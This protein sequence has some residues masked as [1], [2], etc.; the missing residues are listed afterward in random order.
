MS[1]QKLF[2]VLLA[3][4]FA[5]AMMFT[6]LMAQADTKYWYGGSGRWDDSSHWSKRAGGDV[7][8]VGQPVAGDDVYLNSSDSTN[9]TVTYYN[10][11]YPDAMLGRLEIDAT[12]T[13]TM[14]LQLGDLSDYQ[15]LI[16][17]RE[18]IG[19]S[20]TGTL[21]QAGGSNTNNSLT[22]GTLT[23][24]SGTYNLSGGSLSFTNNEIIGSSGTGVFNQT[25]GTNTTVLG[26]LHVGTSSGG[27]GTYNLSGGSLS[28][29]WEYIGTYGTGIFNQTGGTHTVGAYLY[30]GGDTGSGTYT[31]SGGGTLDVQ[32][33]LVI[34]TLGH[35][36]LNGGTITITG[37]LT[38]PAGGYY[39]SGA[40]DWQAGTFVFRNDLSMQPGTPLFNM[41]TQITKNMSFWDWV[42]I[43]SGRNLRVE[44]ELTVGYGVLLD[45]SGGGTLE[46]GSLN[47]GY[48]NPGL[49]TTNLSWA[50]GTLRF[51]H[52]MTVGA[53]Y[54]NSGYE[55]LTI[56][57][58]YGFQTLDVV[59]TLTVASGGTLNLSQG[60]ITA[61]GID[62]TSATGFN[63]TGGGITVD[64]GPF[65]F[66]SNTG[67]LGGQLIIGD[68]H[69]GGI[70][71]KNGATLHLG[72]AAA[73]VVADDGTTG[74]FN[75]LG[76]SSVTSWV[77]DVASVSFNGRTHGVVNVD[78]ANSAWTMSGRFSV[79][80]SGT[81][82]GQAEVWISDGGRIT[83][84]SGYIGYAHGTLGYSDV[85][86]DVSGVNTNG[87]RSQW[88]MTGDLTIGNPS[89]S[90][91]T[92]GAER[93][94]NISHGALVSDATGTVS[95]AGKTIVYVQNQNSLWKNNG[96]VY[97]GVYGQGS[98]IVGPGGKVTQEKDYANGGQTILGS[99]VGSY[100]YIGVYGGSYIGSGQMVVGLQG[101][102]Q[103][104]VLQGGYVYSSESEIG[105]LATGSGAVLVSGNGSL[106]DI[107]RCLH[108]GGRQYYNGGSGSLTIGQG[109]TVDVDETLQ[110]HFN[111]DAGSVAGTVTLNGGTLRVGAMAPAPIDPMFDQPV[112][113]LF[114][115][116]AGS[117]IVDNS[118]FS[119]GTLGSL[120]TV[121][122][123]PTRHLTVYK[124]LS[125]D[126]GGLL[127]LGDDVFRFDDG[128][129]IKLT[130]GQLR[131]N[132]GTLDWKE[133]ILE[134]TDTPELQLS[135]N[136]G[137]L[138]PF[139]NV[140]TLSQAL[141][142]YS[143]QTLKVSGSIYL[144][145]TDNARLILDGGTLE[146]GGGLYGSKGGL[147]W[148]SGTITLHATDVLVVQSSIFDGE[149]IGVGS[150]LN[151]NNLKIQSNAGMTINGGT[152]NATTVLVNSGGYLG[153]TGTIT[154]NV[155]LANGGVIKPGNSPGTLTINGDFFSSGN[156][157]FEIGGITAG[158]YDVLNITGD[159]YF[160]GGNIGFE[161]IDGYTPLTGDS[162]DF[163]LANSING[164]D[165]IQFYYVGLG[166]GWTFDYGTD[167]KLIVASAGPVPIPAAV[168]LLG[169]GLVGLVGLRRKFQ[170]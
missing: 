169:S 118:D 28:T 44:G 145:S 92:A 68:T 167:G 105:A 40:L 128:Q 31:L 88:T 127:T 98:L 1:K 165:T 103:L 48:Q 100:G 63:Y 4:A 33:D 13:G 10:S 56:D 163:L 144:Y 49:G 119:I 19:K 16:C 110:L 42:K 154:G 24:S 164:W 6:P 75:I 15:T 96:N 89:E 107:S 113:S 67:I 46:V 26:T 161:F 139:G 160:T 151:V 38:A 142:Q 65:N 45:L 155:T 80:G 53:G 14:A 73:I 59:G 74:Q 114:T 133:G 158:L 135:N 62:L 5:A 97:I 50:D 150:H 69:P 8:G 132:G 143:A 95:G 168:W 117:L 27:R 18:V 129:N 22:L 77:G 84:G 162:W 121:S 35:L 101:S 90:I 64:G 3:S 156:L 9:T 91:S 17:D 20:G 126:N 148:R 130:V 136:G 82:G 152:L 149:V 32:R 76:G 11:A 30:L 94:L 7:P 2:L 83:S 125:L 93:R 29:Y 159:A 122:L 23:G 115:W 54:G 61:N 58:S 34:G 37:S 138:A 51:L 104:T 123:D 134:L 166:P 137:T 25:G 36:T 21:N 153:G 72:N 124:T 81:A 106:W 140:L 60:Q 79:G 141:S 116:N 70:T 43:D 39:P 146:A 87:D 57:S 108:I 85:L 120:E 102:G 41:P 111:R 112:H 131:N 55:T 86:V 147:D 170:K 52:G 78:G 109:G 99:G 71:L 157:L 66:G 47:L 12:G